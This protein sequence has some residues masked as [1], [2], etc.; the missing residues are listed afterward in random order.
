MKPFAPENRP[1][2]YLVALPLAVAVL[3]LG[4]WTAALAL[5]A[6]LAWRWGVGFK[7][8]TP[9]PGPPRLRLETIGASHIVEKARWHLDRLGA[10]YEEDRVGGVLGILFLARSV[11]RLHVEA[12]AS[13][14]TIG[15]S[16]EI[17]RFLWGRYSTSHPKEAAFLQPTVESLELERRIDAYAEDV[18]R[19]IYHRLL[20]HRTEMLR[21]WGSDD[22]ALPAW[23]KTFMRVAYPL[24]AGFVIR[25]LEVTPERSRRSEA[26]A[27]AFLAQ[28]EQRLER[29]GPVLQRGPLHSI[30]L[31]L[32]AASALWVRPFEFGGRWYAE[33]YDLPRERWP[34]EIREDLERLHEEFPHTT[35][36]TRRLYAEERAP[37]PRL[38]E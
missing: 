34:R 4:P 26:S 29:G 3:G 1:N 8:L 19:M 20:P 18:R 6:G 36:Y 30:D 31:Q 2:L 5:L 22:P 24:L 13:R 35:A 21:F 14:S 9:L 15:D 7:A 27:R 17:L 38:S 23:Q 25:G 11:P 10:P 28:M 33:H 37:R 12:G 16:R 32:A